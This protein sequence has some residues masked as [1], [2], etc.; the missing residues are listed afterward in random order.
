[1][2]LK[3]NKCEIKKTLIEFIKT[4]EIYEYCDLIF[5]VMDIEDHPELFM[6]ASDEVLFFV[7]YIESLKRKNNCGWQCEIVDCY[8]I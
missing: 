7:E 2:N 8:Y 5:A 3:I 6:V 4:N 1:M